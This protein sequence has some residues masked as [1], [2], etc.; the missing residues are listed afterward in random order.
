ML[1]AQ[2]QEV[3]GKL[4]KNAD[5]AQQQLSPANSIEEQAKSYELI[6]DT[7]IAFAESCSEN[8]LEASSR[9]LHDMQEL[10][11]Q[12][13]E[14]MRRRHASGTVHG[15][16]GQGSLPQSGRVRFESMREVHQ[17]VQ[18]ILTGNADD[19]CEALEHS[20]AFRALLWEELSDNAQN[21]GQQL[22]TEE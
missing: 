3:I 8:D 2:A 21:A 4:G 9:L 18:Q 13:V 19:Y 12:E 1:S 7:H 22:R 15:S 6:R 16:G 10:M 5:R 11:E 20:D 17:S 14:K